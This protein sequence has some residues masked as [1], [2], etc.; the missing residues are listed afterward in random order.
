M[1]API[2]PVDGTAPGPT[3]WRAPVDRRPTALQTVLEPAYT[4]PP[5]VLAR[6]NAR[7]L[8]PATAPRV[9][10]EPPLRPTVYL[11]DKL[12]V[13]GVT[14]DFARSALTAAA[15][16]KQLKLVPPV[17]EDGPSRSEQ[18]VSA[19]RAAGHPEP[20]QATPTLHSLEPVD[21]AAAVADA[22]DVLQ[23]FRAQPHVDFAAG[24]HVA[25]DHLLSA[26]R[27]THGSPFN[28]I[29]ASMEPDDSYGTPGWGGRGP[30]GVVM[31]P[32]PRLTLDQLPG[33][34]RPV[35]AILDTG[36][37][38]HPW[39][40]DDIVTRDPV[41]A[42]VP[43][44]LPSGIDD[45]EGTGVVTDRLEGQLDPDAGHGTFI[46][47]LVRQ[48]CPDADLLSVRVMPSDGAVPEHVL[49]DSLHLL[50]L[51]QAEA[52]RKQDPTQIIDVLSLSLGYYHE[53]VADA[54]FDLL[55]LQPLAELARCGVAVTVAAGN[56]ATTRPMFPAAF[57]ARPGGVAGPAEH[58]SVPLISVGAL[59]P[60]GPIA[61]FSNAGP[62]VS[63]HRPGAALVSTF[64]TTFD[65]SGQASA[66]VGSGANLRATIDPDNFAGGFGTWSGTSFA[67][68][69][70]AGELAQA[71]VTGPD[72]AE[73]AVVDADS[74]VSRGWAAV[75]ACTDLVRP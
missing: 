9:A 52:V 13:S 2:P 12:L 64:P 67:A 17:S 51:R 47:G 15:A 14:P 27:H 75:T 65:A 48:L 60:A 11:A 59:N 18:L 37:G 57:A 46:A 16:A 4:V 53:Q 50:A 1:N 38:R 22:F 28:P 23:A 42:G 66:A 72:A 69:V 29:A 55:L 49:L 43:I 39:L 71:L 7:V 62:W 10:G 21:G 32:P 68:P 63:C 41:Y 5:E 44:G 56:D 45:S 73:L 19:A 20:E 35:V 61:L 54:E 58:D 26:C 30:V 6:Y 36:V 34:R 31:R 70:L 25:L 3:V 24:Q 8:D 40:T 74:M 33:R